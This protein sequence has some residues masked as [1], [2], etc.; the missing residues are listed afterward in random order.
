M[1][2]RFSFKNFRS[3]G[4]DPVT[5]DMVSTA[6]IRSFKK[7]IC[8]SSQ[9]AHVL[10]DAVIYGGNASGK[11]TVFT[12]LL[13]MRAVVLNGAVPQGAQVEYCKCGTGLKDQESVFDLQFQIDGHVYDYGFSCNL[14]ELNV[15]SEWLYRLEGEPTLLFERHGSQRVDCFGLEQGLTESDQMRLEVYRDDFIH[16]VCEGIGSELFLSALGNGRSYSE[17]SSLF[18]LSEVFSWFGS[19][20]DAIGA[21]QAPTSSDF[22]GH[23]ADLDKVADVLASFDTGISGLHKQEIGMDEL[24]KYIPAETLFAIKKIVRDNVPSGTDAESTITFRSDDVFL[25]IETKGT[26]EPHATILKLHHEGSVLDFDFREESDGTKRLFDFMDILF[27][28]SK[29]KLFLVDELSRSFHPMLTRQ[30]IS[31]FNRVHEDDDCQLVFTTHE[32]AIMSF[33]Y[34]RRDEIWFVERDENGYS[35]LYP[36]DKFAT[37]GA[38]SDARVNKQYLEGRY[39]GIPVLSTTKALDALGLKGEEDASAQLA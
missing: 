2:I 30:L 39:G 34:F 26:S 19:H 4:A 33:D 6:K 17:G 28:S 15:L 25:S 36:L 38:R 13:F 12:A 8:A 11:S 10:R 18:S 29:D 32:N 20:F 9:G 22:Y 24:D 14:S 7:H 16:R 27:T 31:L 35:R 1:L 23:G 3:V 5:L 37:D 21:G